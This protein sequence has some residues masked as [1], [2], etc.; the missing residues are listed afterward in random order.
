MIY[1]RIILFIVFSTYTQAQILDPVDL[2]NYP[3]EASFY[4]KD[5]KPLSSKLNKKLYLEFMDM[6]FKPWN[7]KKI[8]I[9]KKDASWGVLYFKSKIY[10]ENKRLITQKWIDNIIEQSNMDDF[11]TLK[12][13][14]ITVKNSNLRIF[15]SNKPMFKSFNQAGE[16][17]PFDYGQNTSITLNSP[18]YVSH[19]SSNKDWVF[20]QA[21]FASGWIMLSDIAIVSKDVINKYKKENKY[22]VAIKDNFPIYK[23]KIFRE[24]IKIGTIFPLRKG[25]L[26]MVIRDNTAKGYISKIDANKNIVKF[27]IQFNKNNL[28]NIINELI[29]QPYGWGGS[30]GNRD[31]SLLTK[32]LLTPFGFPM[33]RHSSAQIQN[34]KY[35]SLLG[36]NNE[37]KKQY[38]KN[39]AKAF[40]SLIYIKGHIALYLGNIKDEPIIFHS[41]WGIKTLVNDKKAR[42]IIGKSVISTLEIGKEINGFDKNKNI[43]SQIQG[44]VILSL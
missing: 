17:Y 40:L 23:N 20:V 11:D 35:I 39:N 31:C 4:T 18:L 9:S 3:Q 38:I 6:Y 43:L 10:A 22:F 1:L 33:K 28:N 16:G 41:V 29:G 12:L 42:H 15:P 21:S 36:K 24:H 13:K 5:I 2:K 14:A 30:N 34:G 8:D 32:D 44:I 26:A 37:E 27:P 25:K 19:Y 7:L